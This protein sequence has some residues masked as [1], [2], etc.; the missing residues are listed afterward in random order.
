MALLHNRLPKY[1]RFWENSNTKTLETSKAFSGRPSDL[2]TNKKQYKKR[3]LAVYGRLREKVR[4]LF[5]SKL[6]SKVLTTVFCYS[7]WAAQT[8]HDD[9]LVQ[10]ILSKK[11]ANKRYFQLAKFCEQKKTL[12]LPLKSSCTVI[13]WFKTFSGYG[14][15][16]ENHLLL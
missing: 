6:N 12:D 16:A 11:S 5:E 15:F 2:W 9:W 7:V 1:S 14:K 4:S 13:V 10:M 8:K 3:N